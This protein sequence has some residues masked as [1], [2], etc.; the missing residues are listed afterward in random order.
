MGPAKPCAQLPGLRSWLVG[1]IRM[2]VRLAQRWA[3]G[4][5]IAWAWGRDSQAC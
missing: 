5:R 2:G 4:V 1:L 3:L